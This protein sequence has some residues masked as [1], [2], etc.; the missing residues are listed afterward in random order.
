[1]NPNLDRRCAFETAEGFGHLQAHE[2]R[3]LNGGPLLSRKA[4][5][6]LS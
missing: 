1:M 5:R 2:D 6:D 3:S 4:G